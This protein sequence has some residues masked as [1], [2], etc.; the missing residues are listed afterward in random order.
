MLAGDRKQGNVERVVTF[1]A[2]PGGAFLMP[3]MNWLIENPPAKAKDRKT[4]PL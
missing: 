2:P 3:E 1:T 4:K